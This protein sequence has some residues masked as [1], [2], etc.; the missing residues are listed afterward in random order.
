[1]KKTICAAALIL[2]VGF[3]GTAFAA[4]FADVAF[5]VDQSGSMSNEFNWIATSINSI[6][7]ALTNGG[8]TANYALGGYE[9]Y[10]GT[11]STSN[12][13]QD[14]TSDISLV[15]DAANYAKTHLYGGTE[16]GYH[17]ADW[18]INGFSWTG[19]DYAKVLILITDENADQGS[20]ITEAQLGADMTTNK[21][22]FNVIAP[23]N[24]SSQWDDAVFKNGSYLG[25][26]DLGYLQNDP[27][28]FT[29]NFTTAKLTEIQEYNPT[30]PEP[31]TLLLF[32]AGL[33]GLAFG[34]RKKA[35]K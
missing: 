33:A 16:R 3:A 6:N 32:G 12:A 18:S 8:V 35:Q 2:S 26:F 24:L 5:M 20:G 28:G 1:M 19:G 7:T 25:F 31:G 17:A 4:S 15:I 29:T 14:M 22:L 10:A 34:R 21:I 30:V 27:T 11:E 13:W 9:R 23:A